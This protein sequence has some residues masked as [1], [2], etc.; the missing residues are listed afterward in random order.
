MSVRKQT[1]KYLLVLV[2]LQCSMQ[3]G[4]RSAFNILSGLF[5]CESALPTHAF[6]VFVIIFV[7]M[8]NCYALFFQ[9]VRA[10]ALEFVLFCLCYFLRSFVKNSA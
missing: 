7:V 9:D 1:V 3:L 8:V 4:V 6:V 2:P 10:A 5:F